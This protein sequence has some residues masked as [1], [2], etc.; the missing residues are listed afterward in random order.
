DAMEIAS[1]VNGA[2][3]QMMDV[4]KRYY[5]IDRHVDVA[6]DI[7]YIAYYGDRDEFQMCMGAP[8][9]KSYSWCYQMATISIVGE[10]V[11]FTLGMRPLCRRIPY[12]PR[13]TLV[14]QLL[15]IARE[16]VSIGTVYADAGFDSIGV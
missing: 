10:E 5:T 8:S 15:E 1:M 9:N 2:I 14:E 12:M 4:A 13:G 16:H 11:K 7:T 3:A 6:I